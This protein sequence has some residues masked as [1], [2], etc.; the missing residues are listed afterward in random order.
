MGNAIQ[1]GICAR[2]NTSEKPFQQMENV[3][4]FIRACRQ[5]GVLEKDVFSTVDLY[6]AKNLQ[7]VL[8]CVYNL[9]A[10]S[11]QVSTFRGPCLGIAQAKL[12]TQ[13]QK[14]IQASCTQHS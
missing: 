2:V 7:S 12:K 5:L 9:G 10:A 14:R 6:E 8:K 3:T 4:A 11:R 1:P 13:D